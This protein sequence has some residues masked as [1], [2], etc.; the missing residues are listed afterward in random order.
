MSLFDEIRAE[1]EVVETSEVAETEV[2]E[3]TLSKGAAY[4]KKAKERALKA[5]LLIKEVLK[6]ENITLSQEEQDAIDLLCKEGKRASSAGS[7]VFGKPVIYKLFGDTP[8]V[9][10]SVTALEVFENTGKGFAEMRQLMKKW[11]DKQGITVVY[12]PETKAYEITEGTIAAYE[13]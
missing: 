1:D 9:G 13:G 11:K 2:V 8:K 4:Q 12:N 3:K 5:A 7:S 10:D 6:R